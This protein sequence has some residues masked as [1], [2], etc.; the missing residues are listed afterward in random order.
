MGNEELPLNAQEN[1]YIF[2]SESGVEMMRLLDQ[3]RIMTTAFGGLLA[4]RSNDV[5]NI[6]DVLD[7]ACGPGG[8]V[9]ELADTYPDMNVTGIDIS[10]KMI[11]YAST[12]ANVRGLTNA[13]FRVMNILQPLE[14]PDASF[15]LINVRLIEAAVKRDRIAQVLQQGYQLLRPDGIFRW[16]E[17]GPGCH[18]TP[19]FA[20]LAKMIRLAMH[21]AGFGFALEGETQGLMPMME[22]LMAQTGFVQTNQNAFLLDC[23]YGKPGHKG[24]Y[25]DLRVAF[26][27]LQPLLVSTGVATQVE[28]DRLYEEA[29]EEMQ[30]PDFHSIIFLLTAWGIKPQP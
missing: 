20:R 27:L 7:M 29:L 17:V 6:Y 15:D 11:N 19:N 4:E 12:I 18:S 23:S 25:E 13:H 1:A 30:H 5:G 21:A 8:W 16:S 24:A 3:E 10:H 28:V 14:F 22:P 9:H 2:G 26:K